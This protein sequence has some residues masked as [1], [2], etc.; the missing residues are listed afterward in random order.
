[1]K[2]IQQN[3]LSLI[4]IVVLI[5]IGLRTCK[6]NSF[7]GGNNKPQKPDTVYSVRTEYV[8]QPPVVIPQYI[9][10]Q[11]GSQQPIYIPSQYK[12]DTTINGIIRQYNDILLKYLSKN[13]YNDSI[14]LKDS[15]GKRVGVVNIQDQIS[16]N[17]LVSR[18]PA[19]SL[20]F[21]TI[22]NTT[23]ITQYPAPKRQVYLGGVIEG[24]ELHPLSAAGLGALYKTKKDAIWGING[25]Y[26]F[27][28]KGMKYEL[29]R[30]FKLSF[31]HK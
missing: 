8:Q 16:E 28:Q 6:D 29:S 10:I 20:T 13:N 2:W 19:Y 7:F 4:V 15:S 11:S 3:L 14:V 23:T 1:M 31:K 5:I 30:Y 26:D 17:K 9:P 24:S 22:Y 18:K 12:P 25:K 27:Y 21:P